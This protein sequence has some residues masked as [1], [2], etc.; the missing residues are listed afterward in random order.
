MKSMDL[1]PPIA[2]QNNAYLGCTQ[3]PETPDATAVKQEAD[4]FHGFFMSKHFQD[5]ADA[6]RTSND[7]DD[8]AL[9]SREASPAAKMGTCCENGSK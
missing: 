1:E 6:E 8:V 3:E 4:I 9:R 5:A 7:S 2:L